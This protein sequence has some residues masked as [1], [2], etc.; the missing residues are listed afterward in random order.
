MQ[1]IESLVGLKLSDFTSLTSTATQ[2]FTVAKTRYFKETPLKLQLLDN[3]ILLAL[4]TFAIQV[5]YGL[6]FNKDPF[7]SFIAGVFCSLGTF[8]MAASLRV[9]LSQ[10]EFKSS[11]NKLI[12]EYI[13]GQLLVFF[14]CLILMG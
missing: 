12:F 13:V 3:L 9:Q 14:A 11:P 8:A 6:I 4:A 2:A 7:N 1:A 5:V 10:D